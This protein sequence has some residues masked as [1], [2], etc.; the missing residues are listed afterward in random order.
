[1]LVNDSPQ[2]IV[3][4]LAAGE[5]ID[6][7]FQVKI[8]ALEVE[9]DRLIENTATA[10]LPDDTKEKESNTVTHEQKLSY[11]VHKTSDVTNN[12]V[13]DGD[14][15]ITYTITVTNT[16]H[17]TL[18]GVIVNDPIPNHVEVLEATVSNT[19]SEQT[20]YDTHVQWVVNGVTVDEPV[21]LI[22]KVKVKP[23]KDVG[24]E[25]IVNTATY[26]LASDDPTD[27]KETETIT[28]TQDAEY[29]IVKSSKVG[30]VEGNGVVNGG[31]VIEYR[32]TLT[33]DGQETLKDLSVTDDIP[34]FTT[35]KEILAI[36]GSGTVT[37]SKTGDTITWNVSDLAAGESVT[38]RFTVTVNN[39]N[40]NG[41]TSI[42]NMAHAQLPEQDVPK[43]SNETEHEQSMNYTVVK[44]SNPD[45]Q[46]DGEMV[47]GNDIITY[48]IVVTNNGSESIRNLEVLD[49][50][51]ENTTFEG[52]ITSTGDISV[53]GSHDTVND[54]VKWTIEELEGGKSVTLKFDVRVNVLTYTGNRDIINTA[55]YKLPSDIEHKDTNTITHKQ[56]SE[57]SM[58]KSAEVISGSVDDTANIVDGNA[59]IEYTLTLTNDGHET[60]ENLNVYDDIPEFTTF[61]NEAGFPTNGGTFDSTAGDTGNGRVSW[62]VNGLEAG[63]TI[64]LKFRVIVDELNVPGV[65]E[66]TNSAVYHLPTD[67]PRDTNEITHTQDLAYEAHKTSDVA[68]GY[69]D[70]N[71]PITY[72]ITVENKGHET[73]RDIVVTD[74]VPNNTTLKENSITSSHSATITQDTTSG[75]EIKW[76][77]EA[78]PAGETATVTFT[79]NVNPMRDVTGDDDRVIENT[80]FVKLPE[81]VD[82]TPTET[83]EHKQQ[84]AY[85]VTKSASPVDGSSVNGGSVIRYQMVVENQG[86]ETLRDLV[87]TDAIP[88]HTKYKVG[89]IDY[90]KQAGSPVTVAVDDTTS[91]LKWTIDGLKKGE[92]LTLSFDVIVDPLNNPESV[93][94]ENTAYSKLPDQDEEPTNTVEHHQ[95]YGFEIKKYADPASPNAVGDIET[96]DGKQEITYTVEVNNT[97]TESIRDI[98]VEDV[99]PAFTKYKNGSIAITVTDGVSSS[100]DGTTSSVSGNNLR[101]TIA[102][103]KPGHKALATFTVIVDVMPRL[104]VDGRSI[105]NTASVKVGT[106]D[107]QET[108][109]VVHKQQLDY[110]VE[111]SSNVT[112]GALVDNSDILEY[113]ITIA[114]NSTKETLRNFHVRDV[115]PSGTRY[116]DGSIAMD[117]NGTKTVNSAKTEM[118]WIIEEVPAG[119]STTVSFKVEVLALEA[120]GENEIT[121]TAYHNMEDLPEVPTNPVTHK[122]QAEYSIVKSSDPTSQAVTGG[123]EITYY[124]TVKNEG[125]ETLQDLVV[126]DMIPEFTRY[127]SGS[128]TF[129]SGFDVTIDDS[130]ET[131]KWTINDLAKNEVVVLE[132]VVIVDDLDTISERTISNVGQINLPKETPTDTNEVEHTQDLSYVLHKSSNPLPSMVDNGDTITYTIEV[133]NTGNETLKNVLIKDEVPVGTTFVSGSMTGSHTVVEMNEGTELSWVISDIPAGDRGTVTFQVTVDPME[134]QGDKEIINIAYAKIPTAPDFEPSNE[135]KHTQQTSYTSVK[136]SDPVSTPTNIANVTGGQKIK[137]IITVENTGNETLQDLKIIDTIPEF[138]TYEV[139]SIGFTPGYDVTF[140]DSSTT[141]AWTI[142]N[143]ASGE[144]VEVWFTVTVNDLE[145]EGERSIKNAAITKLPGEPEVPGN[146]IEHK[147]EL[148]YEIKKSSNPATT[149]ETITMVNGGDTITYTI[150]V[151]N[152]KFETLKDVLV[153][154]F[155]PEGTT[156]VSGSM[157]S[158]HSATTTESAVALEWVIAEI[159]ANETAYVT[160]EVKVDPMRKVGDKAIKNTAEVKL[161]KE[162]E[163]TPTNEVEH[164]QQA[165]YTINKSSNPVTHSLVTAGDIITYSI[166]IENTGNDTLQDLEVTDSVPENTT[167][168]DGSISFT[169]GFNVIADDSTT[170]FTWTINDLDKGEIVVVSFQVSVNELGSNTESS[171][172]NTAYAGL[173]DEPKV[174]S[175]EVEHSQKV[176]YDI[177][178]S[179]LPVDGTRVNGGD[180]VTYSIAIENTEF[181]TLNNFIVQD[182]IPEHT[183]F[184]PGSMTSTHS[185][186]TTE[187]ETLEWVVSGIKTGETAIVTFDVIV[188]TLTYTGERVLENTAAGKLETEIDFVETNTVTHSQKAAYTTVKTSDPVSGSIVSAN[189]I[190]T[191]TISITNT[192]HESLRDFIVKDAVP[193]GTELVANS[194][195]SSDIANTTMTENNNELRWTF[196][197]ITSGDTVSVTFRVK[198]IEKPGDVTISNVAYTHLPDEPEI[199]TNEVEHFM[200]TGYVISKESNPMSGSTVKEG[201]EITYTIRVKNTGTSRLQNMMVQDAIPEFTTYVQ[202]SATSSDVNAKVDESGNTLNWTISEIAPGETA[203]VSFKVIVNKLENRNAA[204]IRNTAF[205]KLETEEAFRST[206]EVTHNV[207]SPTSPVLP[208][209][210]IGNDYSGLMITGLGILVIALTKV[211]E[212]RKKKESNFAH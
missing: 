63:E 131:L 30:D 116:V 1:M 162:D 152:T 92:K 179:S 190:I 38:L 27:E 153:N 202:G 3:N 12:T 142:N 186:V 124:L 182:N 76:V 180:T 106:Q 48:S 91:T 62:I 208:S 145:L 60:L 170:P 33:N 78:I 51:P 46:V 176:G 155:I 11:E 185:A 109:T 73:L 66:F 37:S 2:W 10:K 207:A 75:T 35:F 9:D 40:V 171:I 123:D 165:S 147:Q 36:E 112:E 193:A 192:E 150:E 104:D 194:M 43:D 111:K 70:G 54:R 21:T 139:G 135:I 41:T 211:L 206:N 146:E 183:T 126:T 189:D 141:K 161:P 119:T 128:M 81:E 144:T 167:Y 181:E 44:E 72:T 120:Q 88:T 14:D 140:D 149:P 133:E 178:K 71:Q 157:T 103:I 97:N 110:A 205:A 160:F 148:G 56:A 187:G 15:I 137:Y 199:P 196:S 68:E 31:D 6:V 20:V 45:P 85:K 204:T 23:M 138:T 96:V 84:A 8:K 132:F 122:Q 39:L 18:N 52:N 69:V 47:S 175:P 57:Y 4:G 117:L 108:N 53:A 115:V 203:T 32:L 113:T 90:L 195:T 7:S 154:D 210:G 125:N 159:K 201:D 197:E 156:Y 50:I 61:A 42:K 16:G 102:E 87:V 168:V 173:P 121:N 127:K 26:R 94:I 77:I 99:I 158:T 13:V 151:K 17:E 130:S 59:V 107:P 163:P 169:P 198:V 164:K 24:T 212:K 64:T 28:H 93:T 177:T 74:K 105:E 5:S 67:A 143:L 209:T 114:N 118:D 172:K 129:T 98:V 100:I 136:S 19:L 65:T 22:L 82:E 55:Q 166:T 79:V 89:T 58:V 184:V 86:E 174:P 134:T 29:S 83:I 34:E 191:Y 101:W 80:A 188:D 25:T 95:N 49:N 200:N